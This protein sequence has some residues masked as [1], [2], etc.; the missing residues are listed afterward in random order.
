[1]T[2]NHA[3]CSGRAACLAMSLVV[4]TAPIGGGCVELRVSDPAVRFVAFGDS[5]TRG[6]ADRDYPDILRELMGE[7]S[8][9]FSNEGRGGET[10]QA[11][12]ARLDSILRNDSY[13]NAHVWF[14]WEGGN[15]IIEFIQAAD[16]LLI[17][18]P[19]DAD[20]PFTDELGAQLAATQANIEAAIARL[21]DEG[22]TEFV[23]TYF[24][25]LEGLGDCPPLPLSTLLPVQASHANDYVMRL[26]EHIRA[27][28]ANRG[29][30]LVDVATVG[31]TLHADPENYA[32]CNHLSVQGNTLVAEVFA[33][34][35]RASGR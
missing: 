1:M 16:P 30:V 8:M 33:A 11:G 14:Y 5:T 26:N 2:K 19:G 17:H 28:V 29:G 21:N 15:D 4:A 27:A 32:D 31:D 22:I 25:V 18:S 6:A 3:M 34:K 12:L 13:P 24:P 23:A 9:R 20:Y 10:S 7:A 35:L